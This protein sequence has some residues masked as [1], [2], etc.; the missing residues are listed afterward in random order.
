MFQQR[1]AGRVLPAMPAPEL[2][3][4]VGDCQPSQL[5]VRRHHPQWDMHRPSA[6]ALRVK[7]VPAQAPHRTG[8]DDGAVSGRLVGHAG[9]QSVRTKREQVPPMGIAIPARCPPLRNDLAARRQPP[10]KR[11]KS[12]REITH[13]HD[14][15]DGVFSEFA[16]QCKD[17]LGE[18]TQAAVLLFQP[19]Q[20]PALLS[21]SGII[22]PAPQ[23][24]GIDFDATALLAVHPRFGSASACARRCRGG[25]RRSCWRVHHATN[26]AIV[27]LPKL[28]EMP[29]PNWAGAFI[30]SGVSLRCTL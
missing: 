19:L 9:Q 26:V 16:G 29:A 1:H 14:A 10:Q 27:S 15:V 18:L 30:S 6:T 8:E 25:R 21:R 24:L 13:G 28:E 3:H 23:L 5:P 2:H 7:A 12:K 22:P 11:P 17:V 4:H 20:F